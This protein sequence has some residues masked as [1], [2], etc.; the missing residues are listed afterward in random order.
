MKTKTLAILLGILVILA[1]AGILLRQTL[2]SRARENNLG[3]PL[4]KE[5]SVERIAAI[6]IRTADTSILLAK[7][8]DR[9]V[10]ENHYRFPADFE[11]ITQMIRRLKEAKIGRDF[12][13]TSEVLNRLALRDPQ[14]TGAAREQKAVRIELK[15]EKGVVLNKILI[16]KNKADTADGTSGQGQ[17][18]MLNRDPLVFLIDKDLTYLEK[19]PLAWLDQDL[20]QV[21]P[22]EIQTIRC[23]SMDGKKLYYA[24]ERA[25]KGKELALSGSKPTFKIDKSALK[26]LE[27]AVYSLRLE[28]VADPANPPQT[29]FSKRLD[30][31]LFNGL[32]YSLYPGDTCDKEQCHLILKVDYQEPPAKANKQ[33]ETDKNKATQTPALPD[34]SP[35]ALRSEAQELH[36][37]LSAWIYVIPQVKHDALIPDLKGL[38]E[39]AKMENR[40]GNK[41]IALSK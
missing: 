4:L 5:F 9:W 31:R 18:M 13:S 39:T 20:I 10:V 11:K 34:K 27:Q 3:K 16:G 24:F 26:N 37:K 41:P 33:I 29:T 23:L 15:D 22:D 1:G 36:K 14:E 38:L 6:E 35:E 12:T 7:Q 40:K 19:K 8:A 30:Y 21:D 17:Y 28:D 2:Q 32:T 25:E